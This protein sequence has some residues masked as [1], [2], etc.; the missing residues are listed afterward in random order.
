MT[1][2]RRRA[3]WETSGCEPAVALVATI[4]IISVVGHGYDR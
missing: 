4:G 3:T 1:K 2:V